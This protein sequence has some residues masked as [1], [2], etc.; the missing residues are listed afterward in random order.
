VIHSGTKFLG[1]H[2]D[3]LAGFLVTKDEKIADRLFYLQVS[4]GSQLAPF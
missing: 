3:T 4:V 1:G 2:H